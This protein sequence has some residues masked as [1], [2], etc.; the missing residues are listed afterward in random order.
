MS[1]VIKV[2]EPTP[3]ACYTNEGRV[4]TDTFFFSYTNGGMSGSISWKLSRLSAQ[5]LSEEK[6][7]SLVEFL[8][9]EFGG[10]GRYEMVKSSSRVSAPMPSPRSEPLILRATEAPKPPEKALYAIP[11]GDF[12]LD[13]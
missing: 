9:R 4:E 3:R 12:L 6:A 7:L 11:S 13:L 2:T 1:Y 10:Q 8:T 5:L